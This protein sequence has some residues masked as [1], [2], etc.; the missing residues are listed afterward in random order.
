MLLNTS[1]NVGTEISVE[2]L[3]ILGVIHVV[4]S[5]IKTQL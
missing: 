3:I 1:T 2:S 5:E 4:T